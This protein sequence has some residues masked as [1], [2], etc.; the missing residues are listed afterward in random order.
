MIRRV[1]AA[2][3]TLILAVALAP[4]TAAS[5]GGTLLSAAVSADYAYADPP[6]Y[7]YELTVTGYATCSQ[8]SGQEMVYVSV[9]QYAPAIAIGSEWATVNCTGGPVFWY[10]FVVSGLNPWTDGEVVLGSV[11]L[12]RGSAEVASAGVNL[13]AQ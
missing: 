1:L 12:H 5:A 2:V 13:V 7:Q 8:S 9:Y 6:P 10:A 4:G 3:V 11:T